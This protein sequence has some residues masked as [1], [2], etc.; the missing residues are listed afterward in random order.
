[1]V[2][3]DEMS[4][5]LRLAQWARIQG[6]GPFADPGEPSFAGIS[7]GRTSAMMAALLPTSTVLTFQN[8]GR[9]HPATYDFL[10]RLEDALDRPIV[11]LEMR[12]PTTHGAPPRDF[13]FAIVTPSTASKRGEPFESFMECIAAYRAHE[14]GEGPIAPWARQRLCTTYTKL[15]V[16][17]AYVRSMGVECHTR[18]VGMRF[19]EPARVESLRR[20]ETRQITNRAPLAD[21]RI[22]KR[23]VLSFWSWQPF[24]LECDEYQGNC[25]GCFL[26]DE[27]DLARAM[28]DPDSDA[29]WW[30]A[31]EKKYPGFGG[32]RFRGYA[33]LA[34]ELPT[35]LMLEDDIRSGRLI[36]DDGRLESN[37]F[38]L[39]MLQ[40]RR[41]VAHGSSGVAC[42]C[43]ASM[44]GDADV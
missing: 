41:R 27:A 30:M 32:R 33:S 34:N 22:V 16:Q 2:M 44:I 21:A 11:W 8:T 36:R 26:K 38:R 18:F 3:L 4:S 5:S 39:V 29:G 13:G 14:K 7:G 28:G 24:D 43:E 31:M 23:D 6:E 10:Q 15:R 19:D 17:N 9:E 25:T 20:A 35:R 37:R 12:P 40:E 42:A 1:M